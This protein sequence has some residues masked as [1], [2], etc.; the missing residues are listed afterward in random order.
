MNGSMPECLYKYRAL[1]TQTLDILV[2]D[3]LHYADPSRFNDPLDSRPSL[4]ADV[5]EEAL[6]ETLMKL[7]RQRRTE[8]MGDA[9]QTMGAR[10]PRTIQHIEQRS[11]A[12]AVRC[13]NDVDYYATEPGFDLDDHRRFL[14]GHLIE[15]ELLRRY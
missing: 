9:A 3:N 12:E 4:D 15:M 5:D 2:S 6:A 7:V 14:L 11:H 1:N 13:I 8:E 10:G